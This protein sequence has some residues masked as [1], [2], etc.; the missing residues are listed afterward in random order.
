MHACFRELPHNYSY[1]HESLPVISVTSLVI[2][3]PLLIIM[4]PEF[5]YHSPRVYVLADPSTLHDLAIEK[6]K[7]LAPATLRRLIGWGTLNIVWIE[8]SRL[9]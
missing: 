8:S 2:S 3:V 9:R 6:F 4:L 1:H 5:Q 7:S